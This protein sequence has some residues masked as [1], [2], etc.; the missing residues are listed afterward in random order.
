M[1]KAHKFGANKLRTSVYGD[2]H[3]GHLDA[4]R[5]SGSWT[6]DP[7]NG[8]ASVTDSGDEITVTFATGYAPKQI[9]NAWGTHYD[10]SLTAYEPL[11]IKS[12][13]AGVLVVVSPAAAIEDSDTLKLTYLA[14]AS[15]I[16]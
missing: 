8:I 7:A 4:T 6:P 11:T 14:N 13:T 12:Y 1:A 2:C 5:A 9:L 3:V 10:D 15:E 16:A